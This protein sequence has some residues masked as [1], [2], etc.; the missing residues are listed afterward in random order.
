MACRCISLLPLVSQVHRDLNIF[1]ILLPPWIKFCLESSSHST[2]HTASLFPPPP[3]PA[4]LLALQDVRYPVVAQQFCG[5]GTGSFSVSMAWVLN[6]YLYVTL[7][8]ARNTSPH[9]TSHNATSAFRPSTSPPPPPPPPVHQVTMIGTVWCSW[10]PRQPHSIPLP[11]QRVVCT[12]IF[13]ICLHHQLVGVEADTCTGSCW[14]GVC[15]H[16]GWCRASGGRRQGQH[17]VWWTSPP[18][19]DS[20]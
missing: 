9:A 18:T 17:L 5:M 6:V 8:A 4:C 3:P 2:H 1:F 14:D 12:C 10:I 11:D 15:K 20:R 7:H 19:R 16:T 13:L